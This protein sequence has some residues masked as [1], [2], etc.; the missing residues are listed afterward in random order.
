MAFTFNQFQS[1]M[2]K[3]AGTVAGATAATVIN[4]ADKV[5]K[6]FDATKSAAVKTGN[7]VVGMLP[8]SNK[9]VDGIAAK[10]NSR[11]NNIEMNQRVVDVKLSMLSQMT[12]V[13]FPTDE[14]IIEALVEQDE[15]EKAVQTTQAVVDAVNNPEMVNMFG[16]IAEKLFGFNPFNPQQEEV[17]E[18]IVEVEDDEE[19]IVE[20]IVEPKPEPKKKLKV[21]QP[22]KEE[23]VVEI[24]PK[25]RRKLGRQAPLAE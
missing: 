1:A 11:L 14:E 16:M 4:H 17:V 2:N 9:K 18:E 13:Q 19:E 15:A 3:G 20:V 8:A 6:A 12:G 24:K 5:T 21:E 7:T 25:G 23:V 22:K 10:F